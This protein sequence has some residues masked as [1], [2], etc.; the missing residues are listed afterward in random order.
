VN[1]AMQVQL[2]IDMRLYLH[3]AITQSYCVQGKAGK[4][5]DGDVE[6][7]VALVRHFL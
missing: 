5:V 2:S 6:G 7:D 3:V 4:K 1:L